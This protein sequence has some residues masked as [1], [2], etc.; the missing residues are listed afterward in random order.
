[1]VAKVS[2][3]TVLLEGL[4]AGEPYRVVVLAPR[5]GLPDRAADNDN[6]GSIVLAI[7]ASDRRVLLTGDLEE[8][9]IADLL[10]RPQADL[11]CD[12]LLLPHHGAAATNLDLLLRA[13]APGLL[14]LS[15]RPG[16]IAQE[17]IAAWRRLAPVDA[18]FDGGAVR[19]RIARGS[20]LAER[21]LA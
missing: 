12:A 4:A 10:C 16:S 18:T 7:E 9:G 15:A 2:A 8:A 1:P 13:C 11:R 21:H 20:V 5:R 3:G 6:D 14:I 17:R 19:L